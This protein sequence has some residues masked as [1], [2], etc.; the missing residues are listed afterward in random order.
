MNEAPRVAGQVVPEGAPQHGAPQHAAP[1]LGPPQ[2]APPLEPE[3]AEQVEAIVRIVD[4]VLGD[5]VL[6]AHLFGSAVLGGLRPSSDLDVLV[7]VREPTSVEERRALVTRIPAIS[8]SPEPRGRWRPVE[9]NVVALDAV[10]PWRYP[11]M[12]E[13]QYGEWLR[14]DYLAGLVPDPTPDPDLA[15]HIEQVLAG[16]HTLL[17]APAA[18]I[19][20]PVPA[21]DLRRATVEGL[22]GLLGDLDGD[23]RNVVLTLARIWSTL[24]TGEI[25]SKNDAAAWAMEQLSGSAESRAVLADARAMYLEGVHGEREWAARGPQVRAGV[26]A[27]T[28]EI[29]R[30]AKAGG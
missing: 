16:D 19:L 18:T 8:G 11:P 27:M 6:G 24:A 5:K 20:V 1:Q 21:R 10:V 30:L 7:V 15:L 17:G 9:L 12:R 4:D 28:A 25:S 3:D 13:L 2:V 23:T 29:E 14:A 26:E 22:P